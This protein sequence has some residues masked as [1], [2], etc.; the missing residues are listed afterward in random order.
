MSPDLILIKDNWGLFKSTTHWQFFSSENW[1][2]VNY[3]TLISKQWVGKPPHKFC[4]RRMADSPEPRIILTNVSML[5]LKCP[6][7]YFVTMQSG[8]TSPRWKKKEPNKT[9]CNQNMPALPL[10]RLICR[11][12]GYYTLSFSPT[13]RFNAS[14]FSYQQSNPSY[15]G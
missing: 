7:P 3:K 15:S 5:P 9:C 1:N 14:G 4:K 11:A 12:Y 6:I 8:V 10:I 2:I 13:S